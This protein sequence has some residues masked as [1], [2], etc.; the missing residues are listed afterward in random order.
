MEAPRSAL[1]TI[2]TRV[3]SAASA[4]PSVINAAMALAM[5]FN[6][7]PNRKPSNDAAPSHAKR[8]ALSAA[9][10]CAATSAGTTW[11]TAAAA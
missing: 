1:S 6:P 9:G 3:E 5:A 8:R 4:G 10:V 11:T 2:T 7:G